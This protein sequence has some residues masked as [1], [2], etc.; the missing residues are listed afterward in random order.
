METI[1]DRG[2][3][4]RVLAVFPRQKEGKQVVLYAILEGEKSK[5]ILNL[6]RLGAPLPS[7]RFNR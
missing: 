2:V 3:F 7:K 1:G 5:P 6:I 4:C